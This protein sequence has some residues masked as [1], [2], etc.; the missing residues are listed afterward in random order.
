MIICC[1]HIYIYDI[2]IYNIKNRWQFVTAQES[3]RR[4]PFG[5]ISRGR[6]TKGPE[7]FYLGSVDTQR[8]ILSGASQI[9]TDVSTEV[10]FGRPC[11]NSAAEMRAKPLYIWYFGAVCSD[12]DNERD[13]LFVVK[14]PTLYFIPFISLPEYLKLNDFLLVFLAEMSVLT[15]SSPMFLLIISI[16]HRTMARYDYFCCPQKPE[17]VTE[18]SDAIASIPEYIGRCAHFMVLTPPFLWYKTGHE[19]IFFP[20]TCLDLQYKNFT[21]IFSSFWVLWLFHKPVVL[22]LWMVAEV[23]SRWAAGDAE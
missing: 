14:R 22:K 7:P 10:F 5:P 3:K 18:R 15:N 17:C 23:K 9:S 16:D 20:Q 4:Q 12:D 2:F 19:T 6:K 21:L 11:I 13:V 1:K 8:N